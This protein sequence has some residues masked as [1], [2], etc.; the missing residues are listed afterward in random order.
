MYAGDCLSDPEGFMPNPITS[1]QWPEYATQ[2][3][4][5]APQEVTGAMVGTGVSQYVTWN[6]CV[7][8]GGG[9]IALFPFMGVALTSACYGPACCP[10]PTVTSISPNV[11]FAGTTYSNVVLTGTNFIAPANATAACPANTVSVSTPSGAQVAL[12]AVTVNSP[13]Q[14]VI[15]TVTPPANEIT[16]TATVAVSGQPLTPI[17]ASQTITAQIIAACP[18]PTVASVTPN[19]WFAGQ[20]TN[21][22]TIAGTNFVTTAA[23]T[24]ACPASTVSV[25]TPSGAVV[26]L[27]AV[28]VNSPTQITIAT[29]APPANETAETATVTV[30]GN[31][32]ATA[33]VQIQALG[34]TITDTGNIM[35]GIVT[36]KLTAPSGTTGDLNLILNG[37]DNS[38]LELSQIPFTALAPGSQDLK[39]TFDTI[40]P[41]IYPMADGTWN[42]MLPGTSTAQTVN[43]Q[44]YTL[45]T[46]WTY[47][48]KIFYTQY[49][50]PHESAC[51]G[52][53]EDAWLVSTAVV[54]G[55]TTCNFTKIKLNAQFIAAM[56]MNGTGIDLDGD[57]LKNAAAVNL[58]DNQICAGQYPPGAIGHTRSYGNTFEV[59]GS[60][61]GSCNT[62]LIPDQSVAMPCTQVGNQCP[63][64]VLSSVQALNCGDQLNLDSGDYVTA[65]TRTVADK[66][67]YCSVTSP[68]SDVNSPMYGAD[69]HIDAFSSSTSCNG[70]A[71]GTPGFFYTSYLT[72]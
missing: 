16:E 28:T 33:T 3:S 15:A 2:E 29:V 54:K 41:G 44:D 57:T 53:D 21:N 72:N 71:V 61:T 56:W 24:A 65:S 46:P 13:T 26:A 69:G 11:W 48:R 9:C 1:G 66:C 19:T 58:G 52:G 12:G 31:P 34:A 39:L 49:N 25:A 7:T 10:P 64:A 14:I 36:V 22:V 40:L 59:L 18:P 60:L 17:V 38:G 70:R 47:F 4:S 20:T 27:G 5:L 43:I 32:A 55:K 62:T 68:F 8:F 35:N 42:A 50:I 30:S 45:P 23:A 37:S 51:S 67:P 6:Y 63:V